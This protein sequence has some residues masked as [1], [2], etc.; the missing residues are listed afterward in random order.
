[1]AYN[2][3]PQAKQKPN[4]NVVLPSTALSIT[5]L[6]SQVAALSLNNANPT[7]KIGKQAEVIVKVNRL[8]EYQG[9]FKV[10]LVLPAN[11]KGLS[12][13]EVA[14]P[15]GKNEAKLVLKAPADSAPGNRPN[16]VVRAIAKLEGDVSVTHETKLNVNVG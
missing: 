4:I 12:A 5:V 1:M 6:P 7:V 15:A 10:Q 9:D 8:H 16:L 3:D 11:L 2:K 14:I 13:A